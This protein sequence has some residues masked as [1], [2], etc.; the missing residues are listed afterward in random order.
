M[1]LPGW[2][3]GLGLQ[4]ILPVCYALDLVYKLRQRCANAVTCSASCAVVTCFALGERDYSK[5][6]PCFDSQRAV[7]TVLSA[8]GN[9]CGRSGSSSPS[10]PPRSEKEQECCLPPARPGLHLRFLES[11]KAVPEGRPHPH[12][13]T[14]MQ[15]HLLLSGTGPSGH[16]RTQGGPTPPSSILRSSGLIGP[17][18]CQGRAL[19]RSS[20]PSLLL[21][22]GRN[23]RERRCPPACRLLA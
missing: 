13:K 15:R 19:P 14:G 20:R 12:R 7:S 2:T 23:G 10:F 11:L 8:A 9:R 3:L 1:A 17:A 18:S 21:A 5:R 4:S 22:R 6:L 16:F